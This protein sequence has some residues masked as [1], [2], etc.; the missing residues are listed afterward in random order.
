MPESNPIRVAVVGVGVFGRN[1]ARVFSELQKSG[2]AVELAAVCDADPERA[3]EVA[4]EFKCQA[5]TSL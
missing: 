4:M 1:H 5:F 2:E 3:A